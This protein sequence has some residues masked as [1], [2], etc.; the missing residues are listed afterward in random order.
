MHLCRCTKCVFTNAHENAASTIGSLSL[1]FTCIIIILFIYSFFHI[2]MRFFVSIVVALP[3]RVCVRMER[4]WIF[5]SHSHRKNHR[6]TPEN[7]TVGYLATL[8]SQHY[9]AYHKMN[10]PA[11]NCTRQNTTNFIWVRAY[12]AAIFSSSANTIHEGRC[13]FS[14]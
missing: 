5:F 7:Y 8:I 3:F 10:V 12:S 11:K 2:I 4:L 6:R 9:I 1:L 13:F 14:S